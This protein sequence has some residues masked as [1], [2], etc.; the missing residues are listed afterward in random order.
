MFRNTLTCKDDYEFE[1]LEEAF[2][3]Q[4]CSKVGEILLPT[5]ELDSRFNQ[6]QSL[7]DA[8]EFWKVKY[9]PEDNPSADGEI[10]L[11]VKASADKV[12]RKQKAMYVLIKQGGMDP[13]AIICLKRRYDKSTLNMDYDDPKPIN[14]AAR[15]DFDALFKRIPPVPMRERKGINPTKEIGDRIDYVTNDIHMRSLQQQNML[16]CSHDDC[17]SRFGKEQL[18]ILPKGQRIAQGEELYVATTDHIKPKADH[19]ELAF[20]EKNKRILCK[21]CHDRITR[22]YNLERRDRAPK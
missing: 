5:T 20:S 4:L 21:R 1:Q 2:R 15:R 7:D 10:T 14:P 16:F 6:W 17:K 3:K 9:S 18:R 13:E 11:E 22:R 12:T 19:P 8:G